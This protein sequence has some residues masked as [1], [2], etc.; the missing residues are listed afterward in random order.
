MAVRT[1]FLISMSL[2]AVLSF[3]AHGPASGADKKGV[4]L[5]T[6]DLKED[7]EILGIVYYRSSELNPKKIHEE[8]AKQAESMGADYVICIVYYNNAGY[9]YGSGTAVKLSK[10]DKEPARD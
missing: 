3:S 2:A 8:L 7:Y 10:K 5:T 9:L 6:T 4:V 1:I